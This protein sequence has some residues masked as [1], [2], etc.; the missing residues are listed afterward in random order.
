[1]DVHL[2]VPTEDVLAGRIVETVR[3]ATGVTARLTT[4]AASLPTTGVGIVLADRDTPARAFDRE[5][6][7]LALRL[8][9]GAVPDAVP[10]VTVDPDDPDPALRALREWLGALAD[11]GS[12]AGRVAGA[13]AVGGLVGLVLGGLLGDDEPPIGGD[14]Y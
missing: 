4:D 6:P 9:D 5:G 11:G 12:N 2:F 10:S 3:T 13:A 1:M 7:T 14:L 8:P